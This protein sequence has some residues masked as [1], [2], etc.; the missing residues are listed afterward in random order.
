[1]IGSILKA[2]IIL[3]FLIYYLKTVFNLIR[4]ENSSMGYKIVVI[5][6]IT[7]IPVFGL[8]LYGVLKYK[9]SSKK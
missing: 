6:I 4:D 3:A 8:V 5:A 1:M 9:K 7:L 2:L